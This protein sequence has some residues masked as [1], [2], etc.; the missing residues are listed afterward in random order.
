M[1][2]VRK[3]GH[4]SIFFLRQYSPGNTRSYKSP[5]IEIFPKALTHGFGPKMAIFPAFFLVQIGK[6]NV[7]YDILEE[8][9]A[10]LL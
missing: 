8:N 10:F 3:N 4:F 5:K 1:D 7:F 6:E 9:N 2:L